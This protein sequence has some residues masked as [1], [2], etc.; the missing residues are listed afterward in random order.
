MTSDLGVG[1][2]EHRRADAQ[3]SCDSAGSSDPGHHRTEP[4]F[5][6]GDKTTEAALGAPRIRAGEIIG[7]RIWRL[8]NGLLHSVIV[9]YTWYPG[10]F[11]RS[12][13]KKG[14]YGNYNPG[15]HAFKDK[16][17]AERDTPLLAYCYRIRRH[18]GRSHRTSMR[19]A[20]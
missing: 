17:Q 16:S 6:T 2:G 1:Y 18:V 3:T 19:L 8:C 20:V 5:V 4:I 15:Y 10:V 12:G 7:W 14:G 9:S 13:I 11:E